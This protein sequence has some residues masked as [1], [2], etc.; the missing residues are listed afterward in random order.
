VS[1]TIKP[2]VDGTLWRVVTN[3]NTWEQ[4]I[5]WV[6][7]ATEDDYGLAAFYSPEQ[8]P[9][10]SGYEGE[11]LWY[12]M[13]RGGM[14]FP[15]AELK[16]E[17]ETLSEQTITSAKLR[18]YGINKYDGLG[19]TPTT[20][21]YQLDPDSSETFTPT[22][23][24]RVYGDA[25]SSAVAYGDWPE[26]DWVEFELNEAAINLLK[27]K[28]LLDEYVSFS[29]RNTNYDVAGE[30]P[31]WGPD[32]MSGVEYASTEGEGEDYAPQLVVTIGAAVAEELIP[33]EPILT[34]A[35]A[36]FEGFTLD[37]STREIYNDIRAECDI[38]AILELRPDACPDLYDTYETSASFAIAA[39]EVEVFQISV[40]TEHLGAIFTDAWISSITLDTL[41]GLTQ[42]ECEAIEEGTA[43]EG[44][45]D[46][47]SGLCYL[48]ARASRFR[49]LIQ[50][51]NRETGELTVQV[52]NNYTEYEGYSANIVI[53]AKY[54]ALNPEKRYVKFR[55]TNETSIAKYGRRVMNLTW[56][57][58]QHPLTMQYM[59]NKYCEHHC[60]PVVM[61]S[62]TLHGKTDA[63][64]EQI[65]TLKID[66]K[67]QII[68]PGIEL[69]DE[70]FINSIDISHDVNGILEG[71]FDLE[72]VRDNERYE[73][74]YS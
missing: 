74:W 49:L 4:L 7:T 6:G 73:G 25:L 44:Q 9:Y 60:E 61:A 65:L 58:G 19:V 14:T 69:D 71:T 70:F 18:L 51:Q 66:D 17:L 67:I 72:Q 68:H 2:V 29:V 15:L 39:G 23:Y 43:Y 55:S 28:I 8:D 11:E 33:V 52:Y 64:A 20:N 22:D 56:P 31:A 42:E 46:E 45:W 54:V 3:P 50:G 36:D 21:V 16:A 12:A 40:P 26:L 62:L 24:N 37:L 41:A 1:L 47:E 38:T 57:L 34:L 63:L 27:M 35:A 10:E 48:P 13:A 32:E 5:N 30:A 53:T 59:V